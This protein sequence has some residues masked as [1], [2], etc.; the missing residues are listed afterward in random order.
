MA[1]G[2]VVE[3]VRAGDGLAAGDDVQTTAELGAHAIVEGE[4]PLLVR[5]STVGEHARLGK[6]GDLA[7]ETLSRHQRLTGFDDSAGETHF[8]RFGGADCASGEN[9]VECPALSD[10]AR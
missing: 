8:E 5:T 2:A 3:P 6:C 4:V 10:D 7:R 1:A 9:Q